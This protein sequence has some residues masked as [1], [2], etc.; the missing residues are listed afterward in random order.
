MQS[1]PKKTEITETDIIIIGAGPAG[2][3]CSNALKKLNL[4][5]II[6]ESGTDVG[7]A[8][9]KMPTTSN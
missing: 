3:T 4:K 7:Y 2:L 5:S 1:V 6:L 8:W 9:S